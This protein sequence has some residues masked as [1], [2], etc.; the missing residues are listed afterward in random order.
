MGLWKDMY[1]SSRN[2]VISSWRTLSSLK[3]NVSG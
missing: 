3:R 1:L 2:W